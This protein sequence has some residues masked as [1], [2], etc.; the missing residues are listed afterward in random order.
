[1]IMQHHWRKSFYWAA[2]IG[3][4]IGH[5]TCFAGEAIKIPLWKD[6]APGPPTK[7]Q[8]EPVLFLTRPAAGTATRAAV[9]RLSRRRLWAS[10]DG[11]GGKQDRRVAQ[12]V[13]RHGVR[14]PLSARRHRPPAP[15]SDAGRPAGDSHRAG[16][17]AEW[18]IDPKKIG[19]MGFSAGGHLA[20]TLGTHFD[21]G[22]PTAA[23]PIDR[24]SSRPDF[25]ILCYPVISLTADY[26]HTGSRDNLLGKNPTPTLVRSLSNELQVTS[27]T[28]PAFLFHT[29]EDHYV[30]TENSIAFYLALRHAGVPAELHIYRNGGHGV[31]LAQ[32]IPGT[33]D[34]PARCRAWIETQSLGE[35]SER[36]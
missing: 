15:D 18:G 32:D 29:D 28:P 1:M 2:L 8:D 9:D 20:S 26:T 16:R 33:S 34:W 21:A 5:A 30:P 12:F 13:R 7:P 10:R 23:D 6:G 24:V 17:A 22:D 11:K 4:A 25:M 36:S 19:V 27:E 35:V 31:G 14:P 3:V